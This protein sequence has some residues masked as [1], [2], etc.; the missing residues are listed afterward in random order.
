MTNYLN[1]FIYILDGAQTA[2]DSWQ[3]SALTFKKKKAQRKPKPNADNVVESSSTSGQ[4][5]A[6]KS[7]PSSGAASI[8]NGDLSPLV[9]TYGYG[10]PTADIVKSTLNGSIGAAVNGM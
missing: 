10:P 7:L 1:I 2:L 9:A 8:S 3:S 5:P 6:P 4:S